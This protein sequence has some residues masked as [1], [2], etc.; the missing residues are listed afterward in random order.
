MGADLEGERED[1]LGRLVL[2]QRRKKADFT[3]VF[4]GWDRGMP[5]ESRER[6]GSLSI[7]FSRQGE[8]ADQVIMRMIGSSGGGVVVSSDREIAGF[9]WAHGWE[10]V[11][12]AE[13]EQKLWELFY[14]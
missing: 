9:A 6:R 10:T 13:F 11:S 3:V 1:L 2:Y 12:A 14:Q 4:D 5:V 7:V 8:K